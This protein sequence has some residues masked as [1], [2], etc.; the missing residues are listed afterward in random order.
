[1]L[2]TLSSSPQASRRIGLLI[3]VTLLWGGLGLSFSASPAAA[4]D[5]EADRSPR[6]LA[7]A[8]PAAFPEPIPL[9]WS[10]EPGV[11]ELSL[12]RREANPLYL[13]DRQEISRQELLDAKVVDAE[14]AWRV[15]DAY[16]DLASQRGRTARLD[17]TDRIAEAV[18]NI[19]ALIAE[20][21]QVGGTAYQIVDSLVGMRA[22]LLSEWRAA[23][24][25]NPARLAPIERLEASKPD[26]GSA[27][28]FLAQVDREDGPIPE[29]EVAA[30]LLGEDPRTIGTVMKSFSAEHRRSMRRYASLVFEDLR[31]EG[32]ETEDLEP[33]LE[34]MGAS[35]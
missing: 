11:F 25:G 19:D 6:I 34:A 4:E 10:A 1:M 15:L 29:H 23:A 14:G 17:S 27:A 22:A 18:G 20:A 13:P 12:L 24:S 33:K 32:V 5:R 30:A 8:D 7:A 28:R 35:F 3:A 21:M 26:T 2:R 31:R 16:I 9:E